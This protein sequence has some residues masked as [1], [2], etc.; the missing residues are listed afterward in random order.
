MTGFRCDCCFDPRAKTR[1]ASEECDILVVAGALR[2][3]D[4]CQPK[5]RTIH[6]DQRTSAVTKARTRNPNSS[7]NYILGKPDALIPSAVPAA[8][9]GDCREME[10][11]LRTAVGLRLPPAADQ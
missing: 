1:Y 9:H 6:N 8:K 10:L 2:T 11:S 3:R 5:R 4:P 7:A